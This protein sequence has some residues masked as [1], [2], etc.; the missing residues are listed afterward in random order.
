MEKAS[1]GY[2]QGLWWA[3]RDKR[4]RWSGADGG[5]RDLQWRG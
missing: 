2:G 3:L 1:R 4:R 5:E